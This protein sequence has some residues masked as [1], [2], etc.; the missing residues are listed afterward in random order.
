MLPVIVWH[1]HMLSWHPEETQKKKEK[2]KKGGSTLWSDIFHLTPV[3]TGRAV[4]FFRI[5]VCMLLCGEVILC[6]SLWSDSWA[7]LPLGVTGPVHSSYSAFSITL[8]QLPRAL[9][10]LKKKAT[11]TKEIWGTLIFQ[12]NH[13]KI[14][15]VMKTNAKWVWTQLTD[16]Q[17]IK[18]FTKI[19]LIELMAKK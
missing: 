10:A 11:Q 17:W 16:L 5:N 4:R 3:S 15:A 14:K 12:A 2:K 6:Y 8:L 18:I 1:L 7:A 9:V 19:V 13:F